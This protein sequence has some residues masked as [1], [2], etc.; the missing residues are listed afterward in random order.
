MKNNRIEEQI[1]EISAKLTL[2]EKLTMIHGAGF[3]KTGSVEREAEVPSIYPSDG[4]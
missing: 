1:E 4:L 2:D 3:F